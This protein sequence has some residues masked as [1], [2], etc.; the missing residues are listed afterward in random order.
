MLPFNSTIICNVIPA[1]QSSSSPQSGKQSPSPPKTNRPK[2]KSTSTTQ[3]TKTK[4]KTK[5]QSS[6]NW[7]LKNG[8]RAKQLLLLDALSEAI[9]KDRGTEKV[10]SQIVTR[11]LDQVREDAHSVKR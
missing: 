6:K 10:D 2:P 7:L 9:R 11:L 3:T 8:L 1:A 4:K 5:F